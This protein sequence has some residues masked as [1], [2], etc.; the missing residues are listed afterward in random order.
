MDLLLETISN[1]FRLTDFIGDSLEHDS[2]LEDFLVVGRYEILEKAQHLHDI[3]CF[4]LQT[5]L[6]L[7]KLLKFFAHG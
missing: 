2:I 4:V 6:S 7:F 1:N 3:S 5:D